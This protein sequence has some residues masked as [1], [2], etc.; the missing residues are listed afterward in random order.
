MFY[1]L[2]ATLQNFFK[3]SD[4]RYLKRLVEDALHENLSKNELST[5]IY[6]AKTSEGRCYNTRPLEPSI[7]GALVDAG[8]S[9]CYRKGL[10][11]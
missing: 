11:S 4:H 8:I 10:G 2:E 5:K 3:I 6:P 1:L 7:T 9:N